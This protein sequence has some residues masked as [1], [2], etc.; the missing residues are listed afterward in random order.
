MATDESVA[1]ILRHRITIIPPVRNDYGALAND[2]GEIEQ[3][4]TPNELVPCWIDLRKRRVYDQN[5][6]IVVYNATITFGAETDV[7]EEWLVKDGFDTEG[8]IILRSG[9]ITSVDIIQHPDEGVVAK[10]ASIEFL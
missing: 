6:R 7:V 9:K 4:T 1:S 10:V 8:N 5:N 3:G 2:Y